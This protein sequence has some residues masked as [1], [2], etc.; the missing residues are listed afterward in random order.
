MKLNITS[1]AFPSLEGMIEANW[2]PI[3]LDPTNEGYERLVVGFAAISKDDFLV[4]KINS[5]YK[6]NCLYGENAKSILNFID[7][8]IDCL[9]ND[10][11]ERKI[12]ALSRPSS[13]VSNIFLGNLRQ[14]AGR[15]LD[16]IYKN[17]AR[18]ICS[19]YEEDDKHKIVYS[20]T[21][22][23]TKEKDRLAKLIVKYVASKKESLVSCFR[24]DLRIS[25]KRAVPA[26]NGSVQID[27]SGVN[28]TANLGTLNFSSV[29]T[30][31]RQIKFQMWDLLIDRDNNKNS[32][33]NKKHEM[34]VFRPANDDPQ[35]SEKQADRVNDAILELEIQAKKEELHLR[36]FDR[37]S[38]MG[39]WLV[40][41]ENRVA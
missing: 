27:F 29:P 35:M 4:K 24:E 21:S 40:N 39:N 17:W 11:A 14:A 20:E 13:I 8:F 3:V 41:S 5:V 12:E 23:E 34:L 25:G 19:F 30:S 38:E 6:L 2:A 31:T 32:L 16:E 10:I 18:M 28:L 37:I 33:F 7:L 26:R 1:D 15:N 22:R 36:P 9:I